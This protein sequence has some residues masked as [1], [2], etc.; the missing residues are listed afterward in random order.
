VKKSMSTSITKDLQI[1][2]EFQ[3]TSVASAR[4]DTTEKN[5]DLLID[6]PV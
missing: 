4:K 3:D 1:I 6:N 5:E 2:P